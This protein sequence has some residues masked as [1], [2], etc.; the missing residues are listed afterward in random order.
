MSNVIVSPMPGTVV[1]V[2]V[3]AGDQVFAG[4]ECAVLEAMKMQNVL[5][6]PKDGVIKRVTVAKGSEVAVDQVLIEFDSPKKK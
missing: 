5:R 4:Q 6:A 2:A 3:K 1:S